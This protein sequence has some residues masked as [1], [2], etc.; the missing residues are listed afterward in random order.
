[1]TSRISDSDNSQAKKDS[2]RNH[3]LILSR[4]SAAVS[5]LGDLD[6]VLR[7]GLDKTLEYMEGVAGG[8]MLLDKGKDVLQYRV[9]RGLSEQYAEKMQLEMG[10]GLAGRVAQTGRAV[11]VDDISQEPDAA[12]PQLID[13]EGLRAFIS[14]PLRSKE[15][16]LGVMNCASRMPRHFTRTDMHLLHSLG[17][18]LGT[19]VDQARL[20][21]RLNRSK[22]QY[23]R[24]A[25]RLIVAQEEER[26]R[27]ARDLHDDTSQAL[28]GLTL[29][30]QVLWEMCDLLDIENEEFR[31][32]L[33]GAHQSATQIN[34]EVGKIIADLRPTLLSTLGLTPAIRQYAASN[35]TPL[36]IEVHCNFEDIKARL[37]REVEVSLFRW[38]QGAIGNVI[39]H[40]DAGRVDIS[41]R[42][43]GD[44]LQ[45]EV[46]DDGRGF[47]PDGVNQGE[48]GQGTGLLIM[49]ERLELVGGRCVI[50]SK[51][52][53]G[54][55]VVARF[56]LVWK[57][58]VNPHSTGNS[59]CFCRLFSLGAHS[60][61]SHQS[62]GGS[63]RAGQYATV[64]QSGIRV[65]VNA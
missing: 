12:R 31:R 57:S 3:L 11:V 19:A 32:T 6:A 36:D 63:A 44:E 54:T 17:D 35:L 59:M 33:K 45:L 4:V 27:I 51:P 64:D 30:M 41:L 25:R 58:P 61:H 18:Q 13:M 2:R 34:Q 60:N 7:V 55:T 28:A 42:R 14:V 56:P 43:R 15:R 21:E 46:S 40:A 22:H 50:E 26:E 24:I 1:M 38:A 9:Y 16:V 39:R 53:Q 23:W 62:P 65:L 52:G 37:N 49:K 10:Q 29:K 48:K 20:Y 8:I 47:D 5:G